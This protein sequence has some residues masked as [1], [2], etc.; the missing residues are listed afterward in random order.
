MFN[1]FNFIKNCSEI[2][3]KVRYQDDKFD[4]IELDPYGSVGPYIEGS[5]NS[6][7]NNGWF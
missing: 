5:V 4:V 2:L 3:S 7:K 1:S 6:L